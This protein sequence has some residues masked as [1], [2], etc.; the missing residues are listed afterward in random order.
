VTRSRVSRAD[1]RSGASVRDMAHD[2]VGAVHDVEL[3][4]GA[5]FRSVPDPRIARC[6]DDEPF[7]EDEVTAYV[8]AGRA[9]V[10]VVDDAVV[11]F[12]LVDVVD[13]CAHVEEIAVVP[14]HG[15]RGIGAALI[16]HVAT[17]ATSQRLRA[18]TLTTFRDVA[19]NRPWY[20]RLGF[21]VLREHE[22]S[23]DLRSLRDTEDAHGLPA[24]LRVV[25]RRDATVPA[26]PGQETAR[27]DDTGHARGTRRRAR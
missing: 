9:W 22:L 18:I 1:A 12:V 3:A 16:E 4:A 13:G 25:M 27:H 23:P 5:R 14:E 10:A 21:R 7:T 8:R 20:E 2:D 19:W 26:L 24:E 11:G 15:G 6:A 17:W